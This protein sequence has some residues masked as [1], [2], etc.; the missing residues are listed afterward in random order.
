MKIRKAA[1]KDAK[2]IA[3]VL[4]QSYNIRDLKEGINVFKNEIKKKHAVNILVLILIIMLF[5]SRFMC[6]SKLFIEF[7]RSCVVSMRQKIE[8]S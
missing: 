8:F 5:Q 7:M 2:G 3:N 4:V 6:K 1:L